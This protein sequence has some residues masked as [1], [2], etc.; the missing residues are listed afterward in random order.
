MS[1]ERMPL[2]RRIVNNRL[3]FNESPHS[4]PFVDRQ[5]LIAS[6]RNCKVNFPRARE[7]NEHPDRWEINLFDKMENT[8][9]LFPWAAGT[10]GNPVENVIKRSLPKG[11]RRENS[12]MQPRRNSID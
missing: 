7:I 11:L 8:S 4:N 5:H 3:Q 10:R 12:L 6:T 2:K 1:I 9:D